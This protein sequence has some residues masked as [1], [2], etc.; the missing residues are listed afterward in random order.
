MYN[1]SVGDEPIYNEGKVSRMADEMKLI[2]RYFDVTAKPVKW[3]WYPYIALG[4]ITL[5]QGDPGDGKSTMTLNLIAA[6]S[7]GGKLPDG[8]ELTRHYHVIYQCSEDDAADTIKPRL[9]SYGADCRN[10][11]FINEDAG[12]LTLNDE[13]IRQAIDEFHPALVVIDPIQ[14]YLGN[15][16]D[17]QIAARARRL[18]RKIGTWATTYNC[19]FVLIGHLNKK[20]GGKDLYRGLGS[21]DVVAAARSV[22]QVERQEEDLEVRIVQQIKNSLAPIGKPFMFAIRPDK[23]FC[24]MTQKQQKNEQVPQEPEILDLPRNKHELA[25][26]LI[27]KLLSSGT[28]ESKAIR[29]ELSRYGIG[30]KT[31]Q[32]VK[33][34]LG[35]Q[36]YRKMRKWYWSMNSA[37]GGNQGH[38]QLR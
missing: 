27:R 25:T 35:I 28:N 38:E 6:L 10:I 14:A 12:R 8:T 32:E 1:S 20:E 23:G 11:A 30:N 31:L 17:L 22:L 21:I 5:I 19:A 7:N 16:S 34:A 24:W 3:L 15:D 4:K 2:T 18:M 26:I 33:S 9:E 37:N 13:R 29:E 36:S